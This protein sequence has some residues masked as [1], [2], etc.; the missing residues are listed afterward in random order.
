MRTDPLTLRCP[1][2]AAPWD[3][4][5]DTCSRHPYRPTIR[6][7]SESRDVSDSPGLWDESDTFHY[8]KEGTPC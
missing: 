7:D 8:P 1:V 2:C 6:R 4:H 3:G 5:P